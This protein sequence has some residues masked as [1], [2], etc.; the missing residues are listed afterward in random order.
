MTR[1]QRQKKVG[2]DYSDWSGLLKVR[3]TRAG[4]IQQQQ[5][6]ISCPP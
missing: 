1:V 5:L 4:L 3:Q 6:L 2:N